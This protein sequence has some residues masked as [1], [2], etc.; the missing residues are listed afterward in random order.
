MAERCRLKACWQNMKERCTTPSH[1]QF[2]THGAL[3][4]KVCEEWQDFKAFKAWALANGYK[5]GLPIGRLD[6]NKDYSPENCRFAPTSIHAHTRRIC[7]FETY[8]GVTASVKKLCQI[9]GKDYQLVRRRLTHGKTI[10]EA[11]EAPRN[12]YTKPSQQERCS[13]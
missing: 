9:F 1:R 5:K 7:R 6:T 10:E 13:L 11:F 4:I 2:H 3:G 8:Q 12:P